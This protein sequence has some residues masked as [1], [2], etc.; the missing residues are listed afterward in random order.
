VRILLVNWAKVW[1][2]AVRGGGVNGYVQSLALA[3]LAR[4]HD[5][6]CLSS[7]TEDVPALERFTAKPIDGTCTVRRHDDW[8]G[9][10]IFEVV[11]SPVIAPG[12]FQFKAPL[13]EISAPAL[14]AELSRFASMLRPDVVHLNNIEGLSAASVRALT[15]ARDGWSGARA[16]FS[17]HNYHTICPQV[18]LMQQDRRPCHDFDNGHACDSCAATLD[19]RFDPQL[20]RERR[21]AGT[22]ARLG[23]ATDRPAENTNERGRD[24]PLPGAPVLA[25]T[26]VERPQPNPFAEVRGVALTVLGERRRDRDPRE[27]EPLTNDIRP[28]AESTRPPNDFAARRAAMI[29]MLNDCDRVIA[30]SEFVKRKYQSLGVRPTILRTLHIGTKL[31]EL[32]HARVAEPPPITNDRGE[33]LRPTRLVFLGYNNYYKGLHMLVDALKLCE[34]SVLS[35][36]HLF[37]A[38]M[39]LGAEAR[40]LRE[41]AHQLAGLTLAGPYEPEDLPGLLSCK[42]AGIVPSVW[43]DN[44]PQT[45]M[46]FLCCGLPVLAA[47]LGG[48]PDFI[49]HERNG[50]LFRG[51]DRPNLAATLTRLAR[52]PALTTQLRRNVT[53]TK[54]IATH[55]EEMERVYAQ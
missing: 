13:A 1:D 27:L 25:F 45:V 19:N 7:G 52:E 50:L 18:Y 8:L 41:M 31:A 46:E 21:R 51:N 34:P 14:E 9:L 35:N 11:N 43:W 12:I 44:G 39:D 15:A 23:I 42:D 28:P 40:R 2:G 49:S 16:I 37:I 26:D 4:G 5:V 22:L 3:L 10:K 36:L 29:A 47:D 17:L 6:A 30:V 32:A 24:L 48:V 20:E 33:R 53:P 38:G 54:S 55:A